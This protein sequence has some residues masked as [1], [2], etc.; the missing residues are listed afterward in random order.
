MIRFS[1][2]SVDRLMRTLAALA[3][4]LAMTLPS[5]AGQPAA[6]TAPNVFDGFWMDADGEVILE[7][8]A[9]PAGRCGKIAWLKQ[10][11]FKNGGPLTDIYNPDP[12]LRNR[13]VCGL[14]VLS[15][16]NRQPDGTWAGTVYVSDH[17]KSFSGKAEVLSPT[18]IK[19]TGYVLLPLFGQ[20]EVWTKV[21]PP[22]ERCKAG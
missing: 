19:V 1:L 7:L 4:L 10:P 17:G 8:G 13:P 21:P 9:C 14:D 5:G 22:K 16:F 18:S 6:A 3:L 2:F 20:S 12:A 11:N 15:G